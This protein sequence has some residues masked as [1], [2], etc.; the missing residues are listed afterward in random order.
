[1]RRK[2]KAGRGWIG[3]STHEFIVLAAEYRNLIEYAQTDSPARL[4]QL[5][6]LDI[7]EGQN[8]DRSGKRVQPTAQV[9]RLV[10]GS[11]KVARILS[12]ARAGKPGTG[13]SQRPV[14]GNRHGD[15]SSTYASPRCARRCRA[16]M[17]LACEARPSDKI[18]E[19]LS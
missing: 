8:S 1:L 13:K 12:I 11:R 10:I 16:G 17:I 18:I 5:P 6:A 19:K 14:R 2:V 15:P 7:G 4:R 9:R 3:N